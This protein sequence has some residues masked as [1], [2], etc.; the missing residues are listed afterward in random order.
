MPQEQITGDEI[1]VIDKRISKATAPS[2]TLRTLGEGNLSVQS[3]T[4]IDSGGNTAF[5]FIYGVSIYGG[6]D[7]IMPSNKP[8]V[9]QK[10]YLNILI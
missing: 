4:L 9:Q 5:Y 2:P 8:R 3:T 1:S 10:T 7:V 6:P